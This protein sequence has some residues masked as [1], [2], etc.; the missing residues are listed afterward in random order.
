MLC[1]AVLLQAELME[2]QAPAQGPAV[3]VVVEAS[4]G[5]SGP[6]ATVVVQRGRL[7][8]GDPCVVGTQFGKVRVENRVLWRHD[9]LGLT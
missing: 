7:A 9:R 6:E 4:P 1:Y 2:L 8:V 3:A 5:R